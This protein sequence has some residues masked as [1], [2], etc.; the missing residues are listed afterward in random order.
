MLLQLCGWLIAMQIGTT[1]GSVT[2]LSVQVTNKVNSCNSW[3]LLPHKPES[4]RR[5]L[6]GFAPE[7]A[8]CVRG[9]GNCSTFYYTYLLVACW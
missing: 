3:Q 2:D 4:Q 8:P 1:R 6:L 9:S 5:Y 7:R